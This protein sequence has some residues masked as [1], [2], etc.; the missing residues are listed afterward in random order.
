MYSTDPHAPPAPKPATPPHSAADILSLVDGVRRAADG[1][2]ALAN[3]VTVVGAIG[4]A[5]GISVREFRTESG[6]R[7]EVTLS[8]DSPE[9]ADA[10]WRAALPHLRPTPAAD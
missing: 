1:A 6:W 10:F 5:T 7:G 8:F 2:V 9:L 3:T 4:S